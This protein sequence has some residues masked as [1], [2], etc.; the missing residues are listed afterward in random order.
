MVCLGKAYLEVGFNDKSALVKLY[1]SLLE[2]LPKGGFQ[3]E[4]EN[5]K[6]IPIDFLEIIDLYKVPMI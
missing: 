6:V 5:N 3:R 1:R 4:K 2:I